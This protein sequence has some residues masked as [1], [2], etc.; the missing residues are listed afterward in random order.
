MTEISKGMGRKILTIQ[1]FRHNQ[2]RMDYSINGGKTRSS[3]FGKT[4]FEVL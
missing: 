1:V 3:S 2:K 4:D